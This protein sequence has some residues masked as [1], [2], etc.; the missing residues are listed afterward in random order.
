LDDPFIV[1]FNVLAVLFLVFLNGFFV[2]AEF[3]M[4]KI[5]ETRV[6]QLVEEGHRRAR[7]A[8]QLT[9][10]LD[11]YLSACQLGIT[12]ASLGLGWIGE[13]AVARLIEPVL[14]PLG[15]PAQVIHTTAFLI[16]F[17]LITSLHIVLGELVPK[18]MAIRRAEPTVLW[19]A[20]LMVWFYRLMYPLIWFLNNVANGLLRLIGLGP[21]GNEDAHTEEEILLLIN[22][23]H[24]QGLISLTEASLVDNVFDFT[25]LVAKDIMVPRTDMVVLDIEQSFE[26]HLAV[27]EKEKYTRYPV[28]KRD[29]DHIIGIVHIK[30]VYHLALSGQ[31]DLHAIVREHVTV[32]EAM[33]ISTVLNILQRKH[34]QMAIVMDEY[35]GT[36]GLLTVEDILEELVGEIQDEYDQERPEIENIDHGYSVNGRLRLE[37]LK[38]LLHLSIPAPDI[39]TIGGWVF[40][41]LKKPPEVGDVVVWNGLHFEVKEMDGSRIE[42]IWIRWRKQNATQMMPGDLPVQT[43]EGRETA[44]GVSEAAWSRPAKEEGDR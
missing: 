11:A 3:A 17:M 10:N 4:V 25:E 31:R 30:D 9:D 36:A 42:R 26:E 41:Q 20:P 37:D 39:D 33:P 7:F 6:Q 16:A 22:K 12:L 13:P 5:R 32:P 27:I 21:A 24:K 34:A 29:K 40:A 1:L 23:S 28:C 43:A 19:S 18:S 35:G 2:A 15:L 14:A 44:A 8:K 38:E